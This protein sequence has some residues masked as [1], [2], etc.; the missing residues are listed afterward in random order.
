MNRWM[1][2][3]ACGAVSAIAL[4]ASPRPPAGAPDGRI[5]TVYVT[6]V[7][8]E[9]TPVT[10]LTAADF[11]IKEGGKDRTVVGAELATA[12]M[13]V[14]ILDDDNGTGLFRAGIGL[15]LQR[16]LGHGEF[17]ISTVTGQM[18]K[19]V[20]Y[21][22]NVP[23]LSEA[24]GML[25]ARPATP[26]GGQLME[27]IYEGAR[28]IVKRKLARPV[29]IVLTVGGEEQGTM[30]PDEVLSELSKSGA[31]LNVVSVAAGLRQRAPIY[32]PSD[33]FGG[34]MSLSEVL[35][36]GPR[37]SG[38]R[39]DEIIAAP[40][41]LQNLQEIGDELLNQYRL[42]YVLPSGVKPSDRLSVS[43][44]RDGLKLRAP[45]RIPTK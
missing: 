17:A 43:L 22:A 36:D 41:L 7:D 32:A 38:G 13:H 21:T 33:L 10:N 28:D 8:S 18:L 1:V 45:S 9:G 42:T 26:D 5:R 30:E 2:L 12:P 34:D 27:G 37:Q 31:I 23:A 16:L 35:G 29:I 6:V 15:F 39:H 40:G 25:G 3:V 24:L 14:L 11:V 20:D 4:A 19:I 44:I